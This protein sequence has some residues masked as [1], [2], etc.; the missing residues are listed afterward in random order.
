MRDTLTWF[1]DGGGDVMLSGD[2]RRILQNELTR[3]QVYKARM[4][5]VFDAPA[6]SKLWETCTECGGKGHYIHPPDRTGENAYQAGCEQ[7]FGLGEEFLGTDEDGYE[8]LARLRGL[9][10]AACKVLKDTNGKEAQHT[11]TV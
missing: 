9:E 3:L 7:C 2:Q 5:K 8:E 11:E 6:S 10:L 1:L 4:V